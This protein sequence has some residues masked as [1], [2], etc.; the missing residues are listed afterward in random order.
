MKDIEVFGRK[1]IDLPDL[2]EILFLFT[3]DF[4]F[5]FF[6]VKFI[7]MNVTKSRE[8]VFTFFIFNIIIFFLCTMLS[9]VKLKVGFAFGLFAILSILRY[10]TETVPIKEMTFL[11]ISITVGVINSLVGKNVSVAEI[12]FTNGVILV[13]TYI[14]EWKWLRT[15]SNT[16]MIK[17]EKIEFIKPENKQELLDDLSTRLGCRV[18]DAEVDSV[19]FLNDTAM[20]KVFYDA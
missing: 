8:H 13:T 19:D 2:G 11:F 14:I 1:L 7:Y 18:T 6:I 12:V 9:S 15:Y 5:V 3:I 20:V 4:L 17:Y 16:K 10:R